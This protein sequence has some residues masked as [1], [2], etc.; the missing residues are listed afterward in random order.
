MKRRHPPSVAVED[1]MSRE[2]G[3]DVD[4][5][6][7]VRNIDMD[8]GP[9]SLN[10]EYFEDIPVVK[11]LET[12]ILRSSVPLPSPVVLDLVLKMTSGVLK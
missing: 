4:G 3:R 9:L 6:F 7:D 2:E 11:T 1:L 5:G 8:G 12:K 10:G